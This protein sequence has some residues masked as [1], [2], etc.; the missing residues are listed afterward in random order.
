MSKKNNTG[1]MK[2]TEIT[3]V[4]DLQEES[5]YSA[6]DLFQI[7][8]NHGFPAS[9]YWLNLIQTKGY[10]APSRLPSTSDTHSK[11][12]FTGGQIKA[13]IKLLVKDI[14]AKKI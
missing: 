2:V 12:V 6:K 5:I 9:K 3:M 14:E 8:K 7:F 10:I 13:C 11:R 4:D 1:G